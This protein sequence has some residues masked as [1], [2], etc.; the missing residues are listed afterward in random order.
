MLC[1]C[2]AKCLQC[3][4]DADRMRV[5]AASFF[6]AHRHLSFI[7]RLLWS[8]ARAQAH[9]RSIELHAPHIRGTGD[10]KPNPSCC[11]DLSNQRNSP[12]VANC[13][14]L[15]CRH[16]CRYYKRLI[17]V[18]TTTAFVRSSGSS[19]RRLQHLFPPHDTHSSRRPCLLSGQTLGSRPSESSLRR[20][21][22]ISI[23]S[24][25]VCLFM[26]RSSSSTDPSR[27]CSSAF[28]CDI[29]FMI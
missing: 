6:E 27:S 24:L 17:I 14:T 29:S 15:R 12:P 26:W 4:G 20:H 19:A 8:H 18:P 10:N 23:I 1:G 7:T 5:C 21:P 22:N 13:L 16:H 2:R 25:L 28:V 3:E 9:D 11:F